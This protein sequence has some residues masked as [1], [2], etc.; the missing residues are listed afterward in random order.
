MSTVPDHFSQSRSLSDRDT[1]KNHGCKEVSFDVGDPLDATQ[2][3]R[4]RKWYF[5]FLAS[6]LVLNATLASSATS[7]ILSGI[8]RRFDISSEVALLSTSLYIFGYVL[9]P[10]L[11]APL[12]EMFG[13]RPIYIISY[14]PYICFSLGCGLSQSVASLIIFRFFA[15]VCAAAVLV[16]CPG[17]ITDIWD[18]RRRGSLFCA[19]Y[20]WVYREFNWYTSPPF[21]NLI[22]GVLFIVMVFTLP[23]TYRPILLVKKAEQMR[24]ETGDH[25]YYAPMER[26]GRSLAGVLRISF[27]RPFR[28]L[29]GEEIVFLTS[30]YVAFVYGLLYLLFGAYPIV[31]QENHRFGHGVGGLPFIGLALGCAIAAL[32]QVWDAKR[33]L[34]TPEDRLLITIMGGPALVAGLFWFAWTGTSNVHWIVP[35][36]AGVPLGFA[37]LTLFIGFLNYLTDVYLAY[38]ASVMAA[39]TVL[40]S[41]AGAGF[42]LFTKQMFENL[43]VQHAGSILGAFAVFLAPMPHLFVKYGPAIRARSKFTS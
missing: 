7:G 26:D 27:S 24:K 39:N 21:E 18:A 38:A 10:F 1:E 8:I 17:T 41:L 15:G 12:S 33:D 43:G 20:W 14:L 40:R 31:F 11:W 28:M 9:G 36:L 19:H 25:S 35:T 5:T 13:R 4:I 23:E 22:S 32:V 16:L 2:F 3:S 42:P 34:K 6:M 29:F 30:V 37:I